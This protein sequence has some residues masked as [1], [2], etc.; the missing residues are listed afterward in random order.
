MRA[1]PHAQSVLRFRDV[2]E[3]AA[4]DPEHGSSAM[5]GAEAYRCYSDAATPIFERVGGT[6]VWI[7]M[8]ELTLIGHGRRAMGLGLHSSLSDRPKLLSTC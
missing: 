6:Q 4:A 1:R 3:Y 7:G 2:A 5:T 8:P